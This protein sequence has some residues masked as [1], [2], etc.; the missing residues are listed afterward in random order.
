MKT[1]CI[2]F[3]LFTTFACADSFKDRIL[4]YAGP[5]VSEN[6]LKQTLRSVQHIVEPQFKVEPILP[7]QLIDESWD[8][9][10]AL[11]IIPPGADIPYTIALNGAG[12]KKITIFVQNGGA[13]LGICAG[14]YYAGQFVDFARG[15]PLEVL[16]HRE[17]AFFPG[18]VRGPVLAEY[19]Y[20]TSSGARAAK[21]L[22]KDQ[23]GFDA[24]KTFTLYYNG[25]GYFVNAAEYKNTTVLAVYDDLQDYAAMIE[26]NVGQGRAILS[27]V[28]IECDPALLDKE[29]PDLQLILPNLQD[30]NAQR[31]ELLRHLIQRALTKGIDC[32][33]PE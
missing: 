23:T 20:Q 15:T 21:I 31:M 5:G 3:I 28:H 32:T 19:D 2:Y 33:Y 4:V 7:N 13:F 6:C 22:W 9:T 14:S 10:T 29:D 17:L 26:C 25:G 8:K 11:L 18:V 1:F 12:N 27:S 24:N 30:A 16:G